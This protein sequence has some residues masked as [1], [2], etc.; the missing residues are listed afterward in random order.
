MSTG[1][2]F[3]VSVVAGFVGPMS[4][5]G[6]GVVLVPART[7]AS[8]YLRA[9][10]ID[11]ASPRRSSSGSRAGAGTRVLVRLSSR[12]VRR[13]FLA[14]LGVLGVEMLVRGIRGA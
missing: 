11:P 3:G 5:M 10:L 4:G 14:V 1:L 13:F 12:V 6:G 9:G 7:G 8:V 2:L